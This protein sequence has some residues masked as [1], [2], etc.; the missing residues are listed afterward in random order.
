M[1]KI[2]AYL[3]N[4]FW[5]FLTYLAAPYLYLRIIFKSK[6]EKKRILVIQLAKIGDLVCTTPVFREIKRVYPEAHLTLLVSAGTR[7]IVKN[8]P[9]IDDLVSLN[10]YRG[11]QGR[12]RLIQKIKEEDYDWVLNLSSMN[13]FINAL[14]FWAQIPNRVISTH[15]G[16]GEMAALLALFNNY[17]FE[18]KAHTSLARHHLALLKILGVEGVSETREIFI[19]NEEEKKASNFL[20]N[21]NLDK[22]DLLVGM[23]CTSMLPFRQW[24]FEKF[25]NLADLFIE[26]MGAKVIFIG[27]AGD[28]AKNEKT[29]K[30]MRNHSVNAAGKFSLSELSAFLKKLKLFISMDTGPIY[31]ANA[32]GVPVVNIV[33]PDD[34]GEQCPIGENVR[35]VQKKLD[36]APC[37]L[38]FSGVRYCREGHLRCVKEIT[39]QEVFKA[40]SSLLKT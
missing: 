17:R 31:M 20:R 14:G 32:V 1:N 8:N 5:L 16:A 2:Q 40:G 9:R 3:N 18:F 4:L 37:S 34:M 30:L 23:S 21:Y 22:E 33:G 39:P 35:F 27:S 15:K 24:D 25:A 12:F 29:Q 19:T 6:K 10:D 11:V 26:K 7:D 28:A 36:C 13:M 38:V